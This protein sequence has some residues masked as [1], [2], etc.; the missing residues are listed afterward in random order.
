MGREA[1]RPEKDFRDQWDIV[2][3]CSEIFDGG[4]GAPADAKFEIERAHW[5]LAPML[6]PE[7]PPQS[8]LIWFLRQSARDKVI[9]AAKEKRGFVWEGCRLSVFP[10]KTKELAEKRKTFTSVKRKL[11]ERAVKYTLASPATLR[12]KWQGL[13]LRM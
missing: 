3:L 5:L 10:D 13:G 6:D 4:A 11:Q 12:F 2:W 9:T 1:H 8:V 7:R